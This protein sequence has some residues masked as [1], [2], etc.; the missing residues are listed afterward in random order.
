MIQLWILAVLGMILSFGVKYQ[1]RS[2]K[3]V[4]LSLTFWIKD[5]WFEFLLTL[6]V[7]FILMSI[8]TD[9]DT[10]YNQDGFNEFVKDK[11]PGF[12]WITLPVKIVIPVAIG[13]YANNI[14]Y[15]LVKMKINTAKK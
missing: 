5:N 1:A 12:S 4:K 14:I 11:F 15:K 2:N 8:A 10:A 3:D 13:Y 9:P 7:L 6:I